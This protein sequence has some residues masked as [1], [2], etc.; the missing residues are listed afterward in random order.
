MLVYQRMRIAILAA[1]LTL[2][3]CAPKLAMSNEAGGVINKTG[4]VGSDRAYALATDH[5]AKFGKIAKITGDDILTAKM[6]FD[7]VAR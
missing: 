2:S 1:A 4:S 7:C 5:C 6:R 3:A